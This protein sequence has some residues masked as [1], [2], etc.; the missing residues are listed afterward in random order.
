MHESMQ[1]EQHTHE[2]KL[3]VTGDERVTE[4]FQKQHTRETKVWSKAEKILLPVSLVIAILFDRVVVNQM[5]LVW[6][7]EQG[8]GWI[9]L[10]SGIFW[11]CYLAVFYAFYW[12]RVKRDAVAWFVATCTVALAVWNFIFSEFSN[13]EYSTIT[14]FVIPAVLMA[15][16]QWTA[17]SFSWKSFDGSVLSMTLAWLEGLLV[18]PFTGIGSCVHV[19]TSMVSSENRPAIK[20]AALGFFIVFWMMLFIIPLLMGAD[21]VFGYYV[22]QIFSR[23]SLGSIIFH[24]LVI[25]CVFGLSYSFLWNIGFGENKPFT[26]ENTHK[27]DNVISGVILGSMI[28]VYSLFCLVQ[29]TYLFARAGLPVGM[30]FSEYAREGFAQTVAIC[31]INLI[32]FGVFLWKGKHG[33]FL[34]ILLG[35]LL[36]L[37]GVM[38]ISGATRLDLYIDAFGMTWLRLLSAWFLIYLSAVLILSIIRL[39]KKEIPLVG[40][41]S[42]LLLFWYVAL[43]YLNP[44]GFIIWYNAEVFVR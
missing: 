9:G 21:A 8:E 27:I 6:T 37:T 13:W 32:I 38:V 20:R 28:A 10:I 14:L 39:F 17:F 11:L 24:G 12:K 42:L 3:W 16:A 4:D 29:F 43:G 23:L 31:A 40:I 44:D 35:A 18:K 2:T 7:N 36:A 25:L 1:P 41:C 15:H 26:M 34:T 19:C 33:K 5:S 30:T 22:T